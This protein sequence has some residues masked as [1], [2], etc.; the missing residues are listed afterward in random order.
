[1]TH[2]SIRSVVIPALCAVAFITT[3]AN[4]IDCGR[5][6]KVVERTI[7]AHDNLRRAD[8]GMSEAYFDLLRKATT[9]RELHDLLIADQRRWIIAEEGLG[10][11]D[12]E[13]D[14]GLRNKLLSTIE[15]RTTTLKSSAIEPPPAHTLIANIQT[16]RK[17]FGAFLSADGTGIY[18]EG[19][20]LPSDDET[21][22]LITVMLENRG[23]L[24]GVSAYVASGR[25]YP[26]RVVAKAGID[27]PTLQGLCFERLEEQDR[28]CP[29][30]AHSQPGHW[31]RDHFTASDI[32]NLKGS[33]H[34]AR[35]KHDPS[36]DPDFLTD[37]SW[38]QSC[39]AGKPFD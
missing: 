38:L 30:A 35:W 8:Q 2:R 9:D 31:Q 28:A 29:D 7:C 13:D 11:G 33:M 20:G 18:G 16:Q 10:S 19:C 22:C 17:L 36:V 15:A 34:A 5:A 6:A 25:L 4:A 23:Q 21:W 26:Y 32:E 1:M 3:Q 39:L 12:A 27:G 14:Q 37:L 24:C